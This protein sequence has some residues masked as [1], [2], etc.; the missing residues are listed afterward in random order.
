KLSYSMWVIVGG[1][2]LGNNLKALTSISESS[3]SILLIL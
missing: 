3:L 2:I 1:M